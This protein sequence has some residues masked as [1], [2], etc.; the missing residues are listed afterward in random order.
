MTDSL[1]SSAPA[2]PLSASA[3]M[4]T[5][6]D[7]H[8]RLQRM[9]DFEAALAR[10]EAAVGVIPAS[11][12]SDIA[13]VCRAERYDLA[14]LTEAASKVGSL[15]SPLIAALT[16]EV[17]KRNAESARHVHWGASI[18]DLIDTA[19]ALELRVAIDALVV[20]LDRAVKAFTTLAGRHR[21]TPTL[22]RSLSQ[23]AAAVPLGIKV[24]A[25]AA[26]LGRSRERLRRVRREALALQ[27][28]GAGGTLTTLGDQGIEVS[29]R[30]A[31][32]LDLPNPEAPWHSYRDRFADVASTLAI[33]TASC[34]KIASD[35][36]TLM[37]SEIG[38]VL[39]RS[40]NSR[41]GVSAAPNQRPSIAVDAAQTAGAVAPGLATTIIA[42]MTLGHERSRPI[43]AATF[44]ALLSVSSAAVQ[45]IVD[46][47]EGIDVNTERVK[48]NF[49][50]SGAA[51]A[52][53]SA[54]TFLDRLVAASLGRFTRRTDPDPRFA[55]PKAAAS[56]IASEPPKPPPVP[57]TAPPPAPAIEP[58]SPTPEPQPAAAATLPEP[59]V[60]PA[61]EQPG[62]L[63]EAFTRVSEAT[64]WPVSKPPADGK[65][66]PA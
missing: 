54:Q 7:A 9:L 35:V 33:L 47:A 66:K 15:A 10:A 41:G 44:P 14:V 63:V 50:A 4:R 61:T 34:G 40:A 59:A 25:H 32:L 27:F 43:E 2:T 64:D 3:A 28:G 62:A 22:A 30:L 55:E 26:T 24:A 36:A 51:T 38:E 58:P 52:Q 18:E 20:D 60:A 65:S 37:Q 5:I 31:A 1:S 11:A 45:A 39:E 6:L 23:P 17:E 21:R 57:A 8:A 19:L 46:I 13:A 48:A 12:G 29:S 49:E 16:A 56:Q 53:G 42:A